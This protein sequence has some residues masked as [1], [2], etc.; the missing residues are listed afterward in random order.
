MG[1]PENKAEAE[2][3]EL[4]IP[5]T[6]E[7][8]GPIVED[9]SH[10]IPRV[11]Y[12]LPK[13]GDG[14]RRNSKQTVSGVKN[15]TEGTKPQRQQQQQ[16]QQ[17]TS[18]RGNQNENS[19][20]SNARLRSIQRKLEDKISIQNHLVNHPIDYFWQRC[21]INALRQI[22][23]LELRV[24]LGIALLAAG[25]LTRAFLWS[26][27]YL[28]YPRF[29]IL[30]LI[31]VGSLLY[32]DPFDVQDQ[33][34][35][36]WGFLSALVAASPS[37]SQQQLMVRG[38]DTHQLRR[39]SFVLFMIPTALEVKTF[40][41]LSRIN[42]ELTI[43]NAVNADGEGW[44]VSSASYYFYDIGF[45]LCILASMMFLL[46]VRRM[47]PCDV[48]YRGLLM[49]YGFSLL[50]TVASYHNE[51]N[52]KRRIPL[53][54][55][56]FLTA[57]A[58]LLLMY[59]DDGMEW[60]SRI[61]RQTFRLSL[62]DVLASVSE[63]VTEDEM[64]QLALLRWICDFW[65][66]NPESATKPQRTEEPNT[67]AAKPTASHSSQSSSVS[68]SLEERPLYSANAS[69]AP[70]KP[71]E[72]Q[73]F[74]SHHIRWEE[75]QP[76]LNIEI[77]HMETEID[78]LQHNGRK[79]SNAGC[80][81]VNDDH[82]KPESHGNEMASKPNSSTSSNL[83]TGNATNNMEPLIALKSM[84]LSFDVDDRAQPAVLAYKTAVESFPPKKKTAVT[85]SVMRRCPALLT[86]SFHVFL[87]SD[88]NSFIISSLILCPF[89][90]VEYYRIIGWMEVCQRHAT[91][92]NDESNEDQPENDWRI[93]QRLKTLDTMTIL[94]SGD[95]HNPFRPPSLLVVWHNIVSSV[96]AL[97]VGLSTARCAETTAVAIEFAG[98]AMSLVKFGFEIS[99]NG[100]LHG[101]MVLFKEALSIQA[102]SRNVADLSLP[103]D[104]SAE[105]TSAAIRAVHSGQKVVRN[106]HTIAEDQQVRDV[107][108]PVLQ[109]LGVL[110]GHKWLWG[111]EGEN[112][113]EDDTSEL[114]DGSPE[115]THHENEKMNDCNEQGNEANESHD[116]STSAQTNEDNDVQ[117]TNPTSTR[118]EATTKNLENLKSTQNDL[119]P[120]PLTPEEE[121]SQVMEMIATAYENNL[122]DDNEK[123]DFFQRLVELRKEELYDPSTLFAMKRTLRIVIE[124]G[125]ETPSVEL[126]VSPTHID[127]S[128][129][130]DQTAE[131]SEKEIDY[132]VSRPSNTERTK[133]EMLRCVVSEL[134]GSTTVNSHDTSSQTEQS[135]T[136]N[137][138]VLMSEIPRCKTS[139]SEGNDTFKPQDISSQTEQSSTNND[140]A[141]K[142]EIPRCNIAQTE[143][144]ASAKSQDSSSQAEQSSKNN[145]NLI[146]LGVAALGMVVGGVVLTMGINE[147][148]NDERQRP[149]EAD[150]NMNETNGKSEDRMPSSTVEIVEIVDDDTEENWVA[151][152]R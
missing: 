89:I 15:T 63:R 95:V 86:F 2:E 72:S 97:Q 67:P 44:S 146:A 99:Q 123:N 132:V 12:S 131:E 150:E 145:D 88:V 10:E 74:E 61:A 46:K 137:N 3:E 133:S 108:Q 39:L 85:L 54:A 55:A 69:A 33:I 35:A 144:N 78:V 91:I 38:V 93:P 92:M 113:Y 122:I 102:S 34:K 111:R 105:Y 20:G 23:S 75:L 127:D 47:K 120:K 43:A 59:Q 65:A 24:R 13:D 8:Q 80:N 140:D 51:K 58:T 60:L 31:A 112:K 22:W 130:D 94:L 126:S 26:T 147:N 117:A 134:E 81:T 25:L 101:A 11:A 48:S 149:F 57:S 148:N 116:V 121:L 98:N 66:S 52:D 82:K 37:S 9:A 73:P 28:L 53:L 16:Q 68:S 96:A 104:G 114:H 135:S 40:S 76:M 100:L 7:N 119:V 141:S 36:A 17:R 49:L 143:G 18:Y 136:D 56:P 29:A 6:T 77:E 152:D 42:A 50:I 4:W 90:V 139:Q 14:I 103:D 5:L 84:L 125:I 19:D 71:T 109:F 128:H 83:Q 45:T 41:F 32:L 118:V 1:F 151:I 107:A 142:F 62:R 79:S 106:I 115:V 70:I 110:V 87:M 138:D 124:N 21:L 64:L 27:W 30:S 129:V